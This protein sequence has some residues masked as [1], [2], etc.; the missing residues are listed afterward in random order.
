[1]TAA[2]LHAGERGESGFYLGGLYPY[3]TD[4]DLVVEA[5]EELQLTVG[6]DA[7]PVAGEVAAGAG[8]AGGRGSAFGG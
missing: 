5:A 6:S 2:C 1:M 7:G 4:L 3:T 8:R